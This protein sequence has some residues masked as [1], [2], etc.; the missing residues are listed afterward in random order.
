[1][2]YYLFS[3]TC[4]LFIS[5]Q[6]L[7]IRP[8]LCSAL[9]DV[10]CSVTLGNCLGYSEHIPGDFKTNLHF[11]SFHFI[12]YSRVEVYPQFLLF[13]LLGGLEHPV[14]LEIIICSGTLE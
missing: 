9:Q 13:L 1:M 14:S 12:L 6:F 8:H 7:N 10:Q 3:C 5:I 4:H 2:N 11:K